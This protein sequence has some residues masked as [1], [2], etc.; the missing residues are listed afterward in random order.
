[1]ASIRKYQEKDYERVEQICA[2]TSPKQLAEQAE[3]QEML[4]TVFCHYYIEQEPEHCFVAV[5]DADEAVGYVLCATDFS[6]WEKNFTE[7]YLEHAKNPMTKY[8][9]KGTI[10]SLRP[11]ADKYPAHLHIDID[12]EHQ[13]QGLGT[14]LI[15]AL[16]AHL[17]EQGIHGLMFSVGSDNE[18]GQKFY[19]KYGFS[20]LEKREQE[21]VMGM[22]I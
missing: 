6:V 15:D 1:M 12:E 4:L 20:V 19:Q 16:R 22:Q 10:D 7:K 3:L 5:N 18:N 11:F 13:R 8:M 21:I 2:G 17:A 14:K 9:G